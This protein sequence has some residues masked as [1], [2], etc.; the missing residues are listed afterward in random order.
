MTIQFVTGDVTVD[1]KER[2]ITHLFQLMADQADCKIY[3]F[4]PENVKFDM[5]ALMLAK[6][7]TFQGRDTATLLNLK[8]LSFERLGWYILPQKVSEKHALTKVGMSM[9][10]RQVLLEVKD[11]LV[12]YPRQI[13]YQGFIEM[14]M[15]LFK[16]LMDGL[17]GP[18][19]LLTPFEPVLAAGAAGQGHS[20][21]V[22]EGQRMAEIAL[23]Y[24][25][26]LQKISDIGVADRHKYQALYDY[27]DALSPQPKTYVVIDHYSSFSALE[28]GL[29]LRMGQKYG[30]LWITL[31]LSHAER[32]GT[33]WLPT[34]ELAKQT[35]HHIRLLADY[36]QIPI[37]ADWDLSQ[38]CYAIHPD[39]LSVAGEVKGQINQQDLPPS[40]HQKDRVEIWEHDSIQSELS[41]VSNQINYLVRSQGYRYGDILI[42]TKDL[43]R[44]SRVVDPYFVGNGIPY[45]FDHVEEM[46]RD[47]F[48]LWL[49]SLFHLM[50]Y[51]ASCRDIVTLLKTYFLRPT[52][53]EDAAEFLNRV[54]IL[55]NIML[56][57]G[58]QGYRFTDLAFAWHF[59]EEDNPYLDV[60]GQ[61]TGLTLGQVANQLREWFVTAVYQPLLTWQTM[62][63]AEAGQWLFERMT[64]WHIKDRMIH[65]RDQAIQDGAIALSR[66]YEQVWKVF[67]QLL[68]EFHQIYGDQRVDLEVFSELILTGF[69]ESRFHIIPPTLDQVTFTSLES[70]QVNPYKICFL[71]GMDEVT[72][73]STEKEA[74]LLSQDSREAIRQNL[75]PYQNLNQGLHRHRL[76]EDHLAYQVLLY[77]QDCLF[78]SYV[79]Q[80]NDQN[81][82]L[83][84]YYRFLLKGRG[85]TPLTF[86]AYDQVDLS[87][88]SHYG[89]PATFPAALIYHY[90]NQTNR[91]G[92]GGKGDALLRAVLS[93]LSPVDRE[94]IVSMPTKLVQFTRLPQTIQPENA[95]ALYGK[96]L[97][98]SISR[99]E[100]Y[101]QDPF[102]YFLT[103]GL[104][105]RPRQYF[106]VDPRR[107]GDY[108]HA[109]LDGFTRQLLEHRWRIQDVDEAGMEAIFES[110][111]QDLAL[112]NEF[113]IFASHP[114]FKFLKDH[115]DGYL[116]QFIQTNRAQWQGI[117]I[118]PLL[119]EVVFGHPLQTPLKGPEYPLASGGRLSL[120]GKIDRIDVSTDHKWLQV[121][122]Y[123]SG[124]KHFD[125]QEVFYGLDLQVLTYLKVAL[126]NYPAYQ[127]LGAFYQAIKQDYNDGKQSDWNDHGSDNHHG[128]LTF[129]G[130]VTLSPQDLVTI[131]PTLTPGEAS[132]IYPVSLTKAGQYHSQSQQFLMPEDLEVV[133]A[134]LDHLFVKAAQE[135]QA[136]N[137]TIRPYDDDLFS[138][139][140]KS[141]YRV[142]SGFDGTLHQQ[143]YRH[144]S[145]NKK[146]ALS[147]MKTTLAGEGEGL[148]KQKVIQSDRHNPNF[149]REE[150]DR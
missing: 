135:I 19:D 98:S 25:R 42:M 89:Q 74:S 121:I 118:Q 95:L 27:Y 17:I 33:N 96:N 70:P 105:L 11:Q 86:H 8:V 40:P 120:T 145:V 127:P 51:P 142:I 23:I 102:A 143:Y 52:E 136:G 80:K 93:R 36:Y 56:A 73:P 48:V 24:R 58:Y 77:G 35:Y 31:P 49:T 55:E 123:K 148:E 2:L 94:R 109:F 139:S 131:E 108:F 129:K 61:E 46:D 53:F 149:K 15:D 16:E 54:A 113:N 20:F 90:Y 87:H 47:P 10:I 111:K 62:T 103:Y 5:E 82:Q 97:I 130:L 59:P 140:L 134:Y 106:E 71:L 112:D 4:V 45:F 43:D 76:S 146:Q 125:L 115:I 119:T 13:R 124:F 99:I 116:K 68:D 69:K 67:S 6:M 83:S 34:G 100:T 64:A 12:I 88:P 57:N 81:V 133:F 50:K 84:P 65:L 137:I 132:A 28:A 21:Q 126:A 26:F 114:R 147:A 128:N 38:P 138:P 79:R 9:V 78:L 7:K 66:K 14:L 110:V 37:E 41:H 150:T 107:A 29:I 104:K 72:F 91:Q 32:T 60:K 30:K 18:E 117:H 3:Y 44:Y 1:K 85:I 122:D 63:G 141:D 75:L 101:Y 22:R 92:H 144:K 39:I